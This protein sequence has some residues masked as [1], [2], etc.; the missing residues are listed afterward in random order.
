MNIHNVQRL[1]DYLQNVIVG[2]TEPNALIVVQ[3]EDSNVGRSFERCEVRAR[4]VKEVDGARA[5]SVIVAISEYALA[6]DL[7]THRALGRAI[8][9]VFDSFTQSSGEEAPAFT[10][11]QLMAYV[12]ELDQLGTGSTCCGQGPFGDH[13]ADL[14]GSP[15]K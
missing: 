5:S 10:I 15:T 1:R 9:R 8:R 3:L 14:Q 6:D 2:D 11:T 13:V 12:K 7:P 4:F